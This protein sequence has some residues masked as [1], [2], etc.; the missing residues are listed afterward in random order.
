MLIINISVISSSKVNPRSA[1]AELTPK[2]WD[3][4]LDRLGGLRKM[5]DDVDGKITMW[6]DTKWQHSANIVAVDFIKATGIVE[7]ALAWNE[8]RFSSC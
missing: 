2:A 5:A 8:R 4:F 6:Y 3:I 1:M 7:T